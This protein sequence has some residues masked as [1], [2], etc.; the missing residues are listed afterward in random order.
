MER[1][2]FVEDIPPPPLPPLCTPLPSEY[3]A[4]WSVMNHSPRLPAT[5]GC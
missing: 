4:L 5:S 1:P 2:C 3:V